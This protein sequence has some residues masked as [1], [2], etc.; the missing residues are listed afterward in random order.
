MTPED[1]DEAARQNP[2]RML[3]TYGLLEGYYN[4]MAEID[5]KHRKPKCTR[6]AVALPA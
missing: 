4:G 2:M 6:I 1:A 3:A 5:H